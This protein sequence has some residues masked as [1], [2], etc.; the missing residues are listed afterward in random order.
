MPTDLTT[1]TTEQLAA[2]H[3]GWQLRRRPLRSAEAALLMSLAPATLQDMRCD[4]TGPVYSKPGKF[5]L[6]T[7]R[8]LLL[9]MLGGR[10]RS[11]S[12]TPESL[13]AV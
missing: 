3:G 4:G 10:R 11:T 12:A 2:L 9:W 1:L 8:D 13:A 5:V 6:Y 7:E